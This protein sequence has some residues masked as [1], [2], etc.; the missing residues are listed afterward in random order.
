MS[1][2]NENF[3]RTSIV[4]STPK[5]NA[6]ITKTERVTTPDGLKMI[7]H[8]IPRYYY[9]VHFNVKE[10]PSCTER[11]SYDRLYNIIENAFKTFFDPE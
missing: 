4:T 6:T 3:A 1:S 8:D 2:E 11:T 5:G 10:I 9:E 7:D